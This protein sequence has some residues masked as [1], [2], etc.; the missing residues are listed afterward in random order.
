MLYRFAFSNYGLGEA[1]RKIVDSKIDCSAVKNREFKG[2]IIIAS[3]F[4]VQPILPSIS[5]WCKAFGFNME[6]D[7]ES[8]DQVNQL[9]LSNDSPFFF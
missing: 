4:T 5:I 9:L 1:T 6:V 8:F 3:T 2:K 7:I